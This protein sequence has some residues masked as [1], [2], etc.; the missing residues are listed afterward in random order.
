MK[1]SLIIP[2]K[3]EEKR[4]VLPLLD[5]YNALQQ[6]FGN[7]QFEIIIVVNN[8]TDRTVSLLKSL[9]SILRANEIK[10]FDIGNAESK[11]RS[12]LYGLKKAKG[13]IVGFTD[14]DGSY[15]SQEVLKFYRKLVT[16]EADA[17]IP[18]RYSKK[19]VF[20]GHLPIMR[21]I[22]SRFFNLLVRFLLGLSHKDTQ[23]GLKLFRKTAV[24]KVLPSVATF[25]W[26]FDVSILH[27]FKL[28][29]YTVKESA[30][31]WTHYDGGSVNF[32]NTASNIIREL[33]LLTVSHYT[34]K[35]PLELLSLKN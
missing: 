34:R 35:A 5:Y 24:K 18:N 11:G 14:A 22:Y 31:E 7:G 10:I 25:G 12:V 30:I 2:A 27:Q 6:R 29:D 28:H 9:T 26:T 17:I 20:T 15:K 33:Y 21:K 23:G 32:V 1:F 3:N 4:I 8:T 19:S 13:D 16:S